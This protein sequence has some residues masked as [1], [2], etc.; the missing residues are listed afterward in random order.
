MYTL[1]GKCMQLGEVQIQQSIAQGNVFIASDDTSL[2]ELTKHE[3]PLGEAGWRNWNWRSDGDMMLNGAFFTPSGQATP[4]SYAE[5][6]S[7]VARPASFLTIIAPSAEV[8]NCTIG[9]Q[10]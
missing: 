4:A 9:Y 8:L 10:S 6:S 3:R 7:M 1:V 5:A 2:K